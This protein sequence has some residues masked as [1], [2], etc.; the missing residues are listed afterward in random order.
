MPVATWPRSRRLTYG[1]SV[2]TPPGLLACREVIFL[3]A[4]LGM[5]WVALAMVQHQRR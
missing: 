4:F 1:L 5:T 2:S 3:C